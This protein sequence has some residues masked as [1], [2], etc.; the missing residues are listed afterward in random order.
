MTIS[1]Q[2]SKHGKLCDSTHVSGTGDPTDDGDGWG[3]H[4]TPKTQH[5]PA[6]IYNAN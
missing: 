3:K 1:V 4:D 6:D 2:V 5:F